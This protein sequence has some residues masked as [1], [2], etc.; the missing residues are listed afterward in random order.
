MGAK[1]GNRGGHS[2]G[3]LFSIYLLGKTRLNIVVKRS[4]PAP[5]C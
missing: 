5:F 2:I 1:S 3:P 4:E